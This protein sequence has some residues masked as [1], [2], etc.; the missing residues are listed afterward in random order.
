[1]SRKKTTN[2]RSSS[3]NSNIL[4][5]FFRSI[6]QSIFN[7]VRFFTEPNNGWILGLLCWIAAIFLL[8]AF[9]SYGYSSWG[10][11]QSYVKDATLFNILTDNNVQTNNM[12]GR[13]GSYV[14]NLFFFRWFGWASFV[15]VLLLILTGDK[16]IR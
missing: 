7:F 15:V 16:L 10:I 6:A 1:M 9:L 5:N 3:S 8:F 11:D 14:S 2:T 4:E 13:L 12:M